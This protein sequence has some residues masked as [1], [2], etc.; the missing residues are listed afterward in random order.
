MFDKE[1]MEII[2]SGKLLLLSNEYNQFFGYYDKY[3][4]LIPIQQDYITRE[5]GINTDIGT[6][7]IQLRG[8]TCKKELIKAHHAEELF[9]Q[10]EQIEGI[11]SWQLESRLWFVDNSK[12][13]IRGVGTRGAVY[14]GKTHKVED[15]EYDK[16][17]HNH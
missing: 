9:S 10:L 12:Q 3:R 11:E 2:E 4:M 15:L 5:Y 7:S 17:A 6:K 14:N 16:K 13:Y 1:I 8:I